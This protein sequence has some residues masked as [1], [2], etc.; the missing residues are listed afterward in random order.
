MGIVDKTRMKIVRRICMCFW[1]PMI[2]M[3][4]IENAIREYTA[5]PFMY[6]ASGWDLASLPITVC[7][8]HTKSCSTDSH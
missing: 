2:R 6:Q 1:L 7:L 4:N 5:N 3:S 8:L